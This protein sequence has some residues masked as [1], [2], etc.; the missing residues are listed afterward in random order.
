MIPNSRSFIIGFPRAEGKRSETL[1]HLRGLGIDAECF[2]GFDYEVSGLNTSWCYEVDNP[3]SKFKIGP[4]L[5][6]L[7]L[8]HWIAWKVCSYLDNDAFVFFED[9]V[10]FHSDWKVHVDEALAH[11][12][13]DWDMLYFG[14]CCTEHH[15]GKRQIH[16]RLWELKRVQCLQAYAV[17]KK[18][19]PAILEGCAKIYAPIDIALIT[20]I[21]Q[22]LR[23]FAILPRI[24]DQLNT[25][26]CP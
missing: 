6:N 4:K 25:E 8:S 13:S 1:A 12:P 9:D 15:P 11:L 23:R 22:P 26:L 18:A 3:G 16:G 20:E 2:N 14:S 17:R 24:A 19:I 5:S 10:R 7:Y 21:K